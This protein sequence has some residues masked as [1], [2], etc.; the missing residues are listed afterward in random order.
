MGGSESG[1]SEYPPI[2]VLEQI[3]GFEGDTPLIFDRPKAGHLRTCI[4][5][6][7]VEHVHRGC[8]GRQ[9]RQWSGL[10]DAGL[11]SV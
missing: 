11:W 5:G 2:S 1:V 8:W 6:Y 3:L 10:D 4:I 7:D 9:R